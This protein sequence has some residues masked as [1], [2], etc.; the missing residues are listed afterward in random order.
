MSEA[1]K[2]AARSR[3]HGGVLGRLIH[4][5]ARRGLPELEHCRSD[6]EFLEAAG[7]A[8]MRQLSIN[9]FFPVIVFVPVIGAVVVFGANFRP[10]W[11]PEWVIIPVLMGLGL[12]VAAAVS[13]AGR[14]G[15]RLRV[16]D[17]LISRGV[18][19]CRNCGYD[20][21]G[22]DPARADDRALKCPE[23]GA[24]AEPRV[25]QLLR[26]SRAQAAPGADGA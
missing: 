14:R 23:C 13:A 15:A 11:M 18:A 7:R 16:R 17:Y 12:C 3:R 2:N 26:P 21:R 25:A 4:P 19:L 5:F 1:P 24:N 10:V 9:E 6:F 20:L 8:K 22:L